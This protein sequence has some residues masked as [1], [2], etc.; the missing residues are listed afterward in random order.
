MPNG[1][2]PYNWLIFLAVLMLFAIG[3]APIEI[4]EQE[5][6]RAREVSSSEGPPAALRS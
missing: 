3:A 4:E 5:S 6:Q 1:P 2:N